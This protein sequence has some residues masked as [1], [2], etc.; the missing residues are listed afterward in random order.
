MGANHLWTLTE[1][2]EEMG[3]AATLAKAGELEEELEK[4]Y[5][6]R[7]S[8]TMYFVVTPDILLRYSDEP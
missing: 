7:G 4:I 2:L 1:Q 8:N 5:A 6:L 3:R